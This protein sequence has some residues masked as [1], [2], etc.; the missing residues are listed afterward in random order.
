LLVT[1]QD[2]EAKD[3]INTFWGILE[4]AATFGSGPAAS[5]IGHALDALGLLEAAQPPP[6]ARLFMRI[7]VHYQNG[8]DC[9]YEPYLLPTFYSGIRE[10]AN[11]VVSWFVRN[12]WLVAVLHSSADMLAIDSSG[13]HAGALYVNGVYSRDVNEIPGSIYSGHGTTPQTLALP[14][15]D[16][17]LMVIGTG[18]GQYSLLVSTQ[19]NDW[20]VQSKSGHVSSGTVDTYSLT[21]ASISRIGLWENWGTWLLSGGLVVIAGSVIGIYVTRRRKTGRE[22]KRVDW[23]EKK[24]VDWGKPG[25]ERRVQWDEPS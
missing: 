4:I 12:W 25:Q 22:K 9:E 13:R 18:D 14:K 2:R 5:A 16:Y 24:R 7:V 3:P 6:D 17:K 11:E 19:T 20:A 10:R 21:G 15:G 23:G 8:R 1:V